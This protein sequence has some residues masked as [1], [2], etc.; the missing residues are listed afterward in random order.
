MKEEVKKQTKEINFE[1][2]SLTK[3]ELEALLNALPLD[4]TFVD[5]E[6]FIRYFNQPKERF[7][8]K[9]GNDPRM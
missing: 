9:G 8:F 4:I 3:E 7:F 5:A 2:G 1:L 6:D